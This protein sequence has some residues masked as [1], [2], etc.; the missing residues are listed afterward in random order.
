QPYAYSP[1]QSAPGSVATTPTTPA[2]TSYGAPS[3]A[4]TVQWGDTLSGLALRYHTSVD[5]LRAANPT[6]GSY[7]IAGQSLNLCTTCASAAATT[8]G[9]AAPYSAPVPQ[10]ATP[11]AGQATVD[12]SSQAR[13]LIIAYAQ[14]YGLDSS[15]PL[16]IATQESG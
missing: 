3:G 9:V 11:Y 12:S 16:A 4:Y 7:L 5:A 8:Q 15:F 6:L 14:Q 13:A 2:A 1:A 10:A